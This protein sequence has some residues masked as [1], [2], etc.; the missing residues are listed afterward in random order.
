MRKKFTWIL[1]G[2]LA[3]VLVGVPALGAGDTLV[4]GLMAPPRT[5][6][7][8]GSDSDA[9]LSIMAN[10]FDGLLE[11]DASGNLHPGLAVSWERVDA[12]TG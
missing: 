2:V 7:P 12:L 4:V 5:M 10:I 9:N 1:L 11:R 3:A 8:H 6:N